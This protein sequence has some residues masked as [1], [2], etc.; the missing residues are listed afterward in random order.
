MSV[1]VLVV[2]AG[3]DH[4]ARFGLRGSSATIGRGP[5]MD[6]VLNDPRVSRRHARIGIEGARL[7]IE[8][9]GSTG[10]TA[11]NGT[12]IAEPTTLALG[13]R[14]EVGGTQLTVVW[15]PASSH[16]LPAPPA[17]PPPIGPPPTR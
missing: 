5:V 7:L 1:D 13:D 11:V 14:I 2:T 4:G 9:L 12:V 17:H 3:R 10:G 8:D 16:P 15:T 6:V